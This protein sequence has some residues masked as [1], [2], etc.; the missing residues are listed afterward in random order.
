MFDRR[1]LVFFRCRIWKMTVN[2]GGEKD[3]FRVS[4]T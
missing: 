3:I 4:Y 1:T 2:D